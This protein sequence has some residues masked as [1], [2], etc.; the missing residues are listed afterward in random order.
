M[1]SVPDALRVPVEPS[2]FTGPSTCCLY[3]GP[4]GRDIPLAAPV[5]TRL[6]ACLDYRN[7]TWPASANP[8]LL[9]EPTN[10]TAPRPGQ[11][12]FPGE[13]ARYDPAP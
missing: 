13:T 3:A 7:Q 9:I 6:R 1:P 5:R 8:H 12:V 2:K 4:D 11:P 10:R